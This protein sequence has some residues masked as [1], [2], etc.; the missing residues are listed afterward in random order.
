MFERIMNNPCQNDSFPMTDLTIALP[1]DSARV[2][3]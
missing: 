3:L 2:S 1:T